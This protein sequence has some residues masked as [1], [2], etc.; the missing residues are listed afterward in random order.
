MNDYSES[1][2]SIVLYHSIIATFLVVVSTII[3]GALSAL[4][5][6]YLEDYARLARRWLRERLRT[7]TEG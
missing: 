2:A 5:M 3:L 7:V 4:A 1:I 6:E